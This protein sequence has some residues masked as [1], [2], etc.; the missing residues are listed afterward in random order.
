MNVE[1]HKIEED[2]NLRA[3]VG[4]FERCNGRKEG[5]RREKKLEIIRVQGL[6]LCVPL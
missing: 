5:K 2:I 4:G 1:T 3:K 6:N